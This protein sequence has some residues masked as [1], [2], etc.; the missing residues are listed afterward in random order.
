[1]GLAAGQAR[2]LSITSRKSDCEFQSM[3]LSHQKISLSRELADLADS[4]TDNNNACQSFISVNLSSMLKAYLTYFL[5]Y[6]KG[7]DAVD[8][9]GIQIYDVQDMIVSSQLV[10]SLSR[11]TIATGTASSD[12]L[13]Q[14]VFFDTLFNQICASGWTEDNNIG[15]KDY[16]QQL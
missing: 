7:V 5:D 8:G 1:M 13:G 9:N 6:L 11:F 14:A 4:G 10:D 15:D 12:D 3:R 2:L 16:L